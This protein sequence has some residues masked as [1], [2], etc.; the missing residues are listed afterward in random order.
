MQVLK[1]LVEIVMHLDKH[2]Y[3]LVSSYG[4]WT[5]GIL[6][7]IVF[8]E[9]GLVVTPFLPGDSL[10]FA[11]G[12]L[13]AITPMRVHWLLILLSLAA[14][15]GDTVN[16]WIGY[17]VGPRVFNKQHSRLFN[18]G[19]LERTR[20]FYEKYGA[21]TIILARFVPIIR[22]FAPF[23]AGIGSMTYARFITYNVI[24]GLLW[25]SILLLGGYFFGNIPV[26]KKNFTIVIFA[27][28]IISVMPAVYEYLNGRYRRSA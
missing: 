25:I 5:Y 1:D 23:V 15:I 17:S 8:C 22:T 20:R 6:C 14:I 26:V 7:L 24:G 13:A 3:D 19:H 16:Y 4:S 12:A 27:I 28:I 11:A 10:L 18:K 2:L 9:T 21:K